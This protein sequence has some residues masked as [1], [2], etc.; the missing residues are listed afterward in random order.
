MSDEG[1]VNGLL[2]SIP[3]G[4]EIRDPR[5]GFHSDVVI[6][7]SEL[8]QNSTG[9]WAIVTNY[10]SMTDVNGRMF[11]LKERYN[12][13]ASDSDDVVKRIFLDVLHSLG[14]VDRSD[15][16]SVHAET[17]EQREGVAAAFQS[18]QGNNV[19]LKIAADKSGY[20]HGRIVRGKAK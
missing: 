8:V 17:D 19:N 6:G 4:E 1:V 20:V 18:V 5:E 10:N 14:I 15:R 13:P 16:R 7:E 12:I 9:S 11:E 3:R 2:G